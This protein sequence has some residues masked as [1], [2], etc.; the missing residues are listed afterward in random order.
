[1]DKD[2]VI[3]A[4]QWAVNRLDDYFEY[5]FSHD[6]SIEIQKTVFDI[7]GKLTDRLQEIEKEQTQ[8]KQ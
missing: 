5:R 4:Y 8:N 3:K 2:N 7:L 1:M 6:S